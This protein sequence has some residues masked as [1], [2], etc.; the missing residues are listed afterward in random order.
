MLCPHYSVRF[1]IVCFHHVLTT[2]EL[3]P[4][5]S[6]RLYIVCLHHVLDCILQSSWSKCKPLD[7]TEAL[8]YLTCI[9]YIILYYINYINH[10]IWLIAH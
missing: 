8:I 10:I 7:V 5:Y 2:R 9:Y 1:Y 6:G 4:H 3:C